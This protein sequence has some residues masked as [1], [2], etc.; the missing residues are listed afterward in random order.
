MRLNGD[1]TDAGATMGIL[2]ILGFN[3]RL[4]AHAMVTACDEN[5]PYPL[6]DVT[7]WPA[8]TGNYTEATWAVRKAEVKS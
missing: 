2:L 4:I 7:L 1:P 3:E 8:R 5:K 6:G